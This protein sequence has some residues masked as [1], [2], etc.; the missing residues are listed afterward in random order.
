MADAKCDS[1][2]EQVRYLVRRAYSFEHFSKR[3]LTD[4]KFRRDVLISLNRL[5]SSWYER[6][7][8]DD[9]LR[10]D[11]LKRDLVALLDETDPVE[12]FGLQEPVQSYLNECP[13]RLRK[14]RT[15]NLTYYDNQRSR[16]YCDRYYFG[17]YGRFLE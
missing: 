7:R 9:A 3:L 12:V 10:I 1:I 16:F 14:N 6:E 4:K 8:F 13:V 11:Y 15:A 2:F 17:K 5:R